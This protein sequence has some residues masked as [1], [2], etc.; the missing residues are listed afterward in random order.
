MRLPCSWHSKDKNCWL[1]CP[2]ISSTAQFWRK[3]FCSIITEGFGCHEKVVIH[4]INWRCVLSRLNII[5]DN[6]PQ[7]L[8]D[9]LTKQVQT[10]LKYIVIK[11]MIQ[12]EG[13]SRSSSSTI[14]CPHLPL[15][16]SLLS[17]LG[18]LISEKNSH[19]EQNISFIFLLEDFNFL[20]F[21]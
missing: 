6:V 14:V 4:K 13:S 20:F 19:Q 5:M 12:K 7:L 2:E 15:P 8:V 21:F 17:Y 10:F 3:V 9:H 18:R 11:C 1:W 16:T